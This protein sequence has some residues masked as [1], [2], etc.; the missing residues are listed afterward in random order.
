MS[1]ATWVSPELDSIDIDGFING[2]SFPFSRFN[3]VPPF[4]FSCGGMEEEVRT[5]EGGKRE[6]R[7]DP[8][9]NTTDP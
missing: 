2:I 8:P 7:K 6:R 5:A 1:Q 3:F 4:P 9:G